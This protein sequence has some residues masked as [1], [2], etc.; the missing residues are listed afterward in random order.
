M[1]ED[2]HHIIE[3]LE[4]DPDPHQSEN[5]DPD[6]H[7]RD[8]DPQPCRREMEGPRSATDVH[9]VRYNHGRRNFKDANPFMSFSL[10]ILFG[11]VK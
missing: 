3:K 11:V 7:Q 6:P 2:S 9:R 5:S 4:M 8:A 10:V 1:V